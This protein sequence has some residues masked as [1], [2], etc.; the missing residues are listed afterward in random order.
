MVG[1]QLADKI[2]NILRLDPA[3]PI[4]Y[5]GHPSLKSRASRSMLFGLAVTSVEVSCRRGVTARRKGVASSTAG[6][7]E[8]FKDEQ[9]DHSPDGCGN[10][11]GD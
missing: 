3:R 1:S 11:R 5:I 10:D 7:P 4:R 6:S 2:R 8:Y 9:K